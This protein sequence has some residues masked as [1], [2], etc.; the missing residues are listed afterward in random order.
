MH[1]V[2]VCV[3]IAE[4]SGTW[5]KPTIIAIITMSKSVISYDCSSLHTVAH[6]D[7]IDWA[8]L[9][10]NRSIDR[11]KMFNWLKV[12]LYLFNVERLTYTDLKWERKRGRLSFVR[13]I[14]LMAHCVDALLYLKM[15]ILANSI[16]NHTNVWIELNWSSKTARLKSIDGTL[17]Q[18][19]CH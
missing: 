4:P 15:N 14:E 6:I 3:E 1:C 13:S 19:T 18:V 11:C 10:H 7:N 16:F 5:Q 2:C 17:L 9:T 12:E 8:W